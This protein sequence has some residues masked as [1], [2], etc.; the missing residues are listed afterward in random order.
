MIW[1]IIVKDFPLLE[2]EVNNIL[3]EDIIT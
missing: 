3:S 1:K 2:K